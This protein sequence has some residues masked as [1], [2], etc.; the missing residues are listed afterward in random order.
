MQSESGVIECCDG[1]M[2]GHSTKVVRTTDHVMRYAVH[3]GSVSCINTS[4]LS[5]VCRGLCDPIF[6]FFGVMS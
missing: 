1:A 5:Y 6:F 4:I 3:T 2:R